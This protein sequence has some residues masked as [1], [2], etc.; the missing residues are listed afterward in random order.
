MKINEAFAVFGLE[1]SATDDEIKR[2]YR[3]L[4]LLHHPDRHSSSE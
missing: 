3:R 4:A 2:T 1:K